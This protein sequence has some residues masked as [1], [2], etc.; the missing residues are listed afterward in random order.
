MCCIG[1]SRV[2]QQG[3][4]G[5]ER[6][7]RT[8][9]QQVRRKSKTAASLAAAQAMGGG[10]NSDEEVTG[11]FLLL[12]LAADFQNLVAS[13]QMEVAVIWQDC[14]EAG[15]IPWQVYQTATAVDAAAKA[16]GPEYDSDDILVVPDKFNNT[17]DPLKPLDHDQI[18]YEEFNKDFY[19]P[20]AEIAALTDGQVSCWA[21]ADIVCCRS[22]FVASSMSVLALHL[23]DSH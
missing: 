7:T 18:E 6:P 15:F 19:E 1:S 17:I 3:C 10:Y 4:H 16:K 23:S 20:A 13:F 11:L 21:F 22:E 8:F 12:R 14:A 9:C 2:S 5:C